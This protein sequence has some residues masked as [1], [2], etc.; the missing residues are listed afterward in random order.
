V[1]WS[2][3][4]QLRHLVIVNASTAEPGFDDS[5][6]DIIPEPSWYGST[7]LDTCWPVA[8]LKVAC[9]PPGGSHSLATLRREPR[10]GAGRPGPAAYPAAAGPAEYAPPARSSM[11]VGPVGAQPSS[12]RVAVLVAARSMPKNV[13]IHPK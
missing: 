7:A 6:A 1:T 12:S 8:A 11:S 4:Q 5:G 3:R 13:P 10:G 2:R 9:R